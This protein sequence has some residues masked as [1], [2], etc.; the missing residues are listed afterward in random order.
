MTG[1]TTCGL[2][3]TT[4]CWVC[5]KIACIRH[6]TSSPFHMNVMMRRVG[7]ETLTF[8]RFD[9]ST[10]ILPQI[11]SYPICVSCFESDVLTPVSAAVFQNCDL[12][13]VQTIAAL[14]TAALSTVVGLRYASTGMYADGLLRATP[15]PHPEWFD[16]TLDRTLARLLVRVTP[17][18]HP[19][20]HHLIRQPSP[21]D[22]GRAEADG[23]LFRWEDIHHN[24]FAI[25]VDTNGCIVDIGPSACLR[26]G[27]SDLQLLRKIWQQLKRCISF[28]G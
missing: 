3:A 23:W 7:L 16:S 21:S 12:N 25:I 8:E 19:P 15:G 6:N 28:G 9:G 26:D 14:T 27:Y 4:H 10:V 17:P 2:A 24:Q 11:A 20:A 1:C 22:A 13:Y 5:H 18:T